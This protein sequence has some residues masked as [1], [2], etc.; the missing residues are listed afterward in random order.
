MFMT[1]NSGTIRGFSVETVTYDGQYPLIKSCFAKRCSVEAK[2]V[3]E[4]E[5]IVVL[6][7]THALQLLY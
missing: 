4:C 2:C 1:L 7:V 5:V 6:K 3:E